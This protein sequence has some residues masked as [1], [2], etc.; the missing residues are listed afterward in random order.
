M[1]L[2]ILLLRNSW[3]S[4]ESVNVT[5]LSLIKEIILCTKRRKQEITILYLDASKLII[6][7]P[8]KNQFLDIQVH[9]C[10]SQKNK[11]IKK[12]MKINTNN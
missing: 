7:L 2:K 8:I 5:V 6:C 4:L 12:N 11:W 1:V 10:K 3:N 9:H